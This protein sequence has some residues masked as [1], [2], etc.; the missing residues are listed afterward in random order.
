[1]WPAL[2]IVKLPDNGIL[3]RVVLAAGVVIGIANLYVNILGIVQVVF[4]Y[5]AAAIAKCEPL[6]NTSWWIYMFFFVISTCLG[7]CCCIGC[8][9][10]GMIMGA[11]GQG[12]EPKNG[13]VVP[14][15]AKVDY[16]QLP[17]QPDGAA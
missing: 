17:G 6:H 8:A 14:D 11:G 13:A 9:G 1:M 10:F 4:N 15:M 2:M 5:N 16:Q 3:Y 12:R 7:C